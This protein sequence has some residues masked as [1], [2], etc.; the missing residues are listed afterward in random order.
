VQELEEEDDQ[1]RGH[2]V[3]DPGAGLRGLQ[4]NPQNVPGQVQGE[5]EGQRRDCGGRGQVVIK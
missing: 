1:R 3:I 4:R 2:P 5:R